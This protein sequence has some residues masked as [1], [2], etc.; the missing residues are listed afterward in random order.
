M[1]FEFTRF[2]ELD[3]ERLFLRQTGKSDANEVFFSRSDEKMNRYIKRKLATTLKDAEDFVEKIT[4]GFENGKNINWS[5]TLKGNQKMI[6]SICLWNFSGNRKIAEVG[7]DLHLNFQNQGIMNEAMKRV[8]AFGFQNLKLEQIEAFTHFENEPSKKLLTKNNFVHAENRTDEDD[9][10][11][12][13]FELKNQHWANCPENN[14][15]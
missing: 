6:G 7:Y 1:K 2:P 13:I 4:D 10:N 14:H 3:T 15:T 11:N 8:L 12:S 5:I 9:P